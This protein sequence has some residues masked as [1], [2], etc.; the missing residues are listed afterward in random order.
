V[1]VYPVFY[2]F[3]RLCFY[4][5]CLHTE[6]L[7]SEHL[8]S[9]G[10]LEAELSTGKGFGAQARVMSRSGNVTGK[11]EEVQHHDQRGDRQVGPKE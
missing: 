6:F 5:S 2:K 9:S 10:R 8:A 7:V 4:R 3:R 1:H 11:R